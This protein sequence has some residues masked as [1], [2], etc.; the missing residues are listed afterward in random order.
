[1]MSRRQRTF[2][3]VSVLVLASVRSPAVEPTGSKIRMSEFRM[4]ENNEDGSPHWRLAGAEAVL[5][6]PVVEMKKVELTLFLDDG[7]QAL[8]TSPRS[9]FDRDARTVSSDAPVRVVSDSLRLDGVGYDIPADRQRIYVRSN[10][11]MVIRD[12][13]GGALE[14]LAPPGGESREQK[15]REE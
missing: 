6:G 5:D 13:G 2:L 3:L 9:T 15:T 12:A 11:H 1:M 4:K 14:R 8:I 10:V 7:Q